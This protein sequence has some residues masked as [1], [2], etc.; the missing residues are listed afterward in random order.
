MILAQEAC[1]YHSVSIIFDL[2]QLF[3]ILKLIVAAG[4]V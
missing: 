3:Q 2:R 1:V 4:V